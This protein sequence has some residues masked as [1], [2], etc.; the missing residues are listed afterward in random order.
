MIKIAIVEDNTALRGSLVSLFRQ[1]R[2][3]A[4]RGVPQ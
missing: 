4:V 2:G 1:G 3:H